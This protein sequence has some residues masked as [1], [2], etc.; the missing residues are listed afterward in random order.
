[1]QSLNLSGTKVTDGGI[2]DLQKTLP[3]T[4]IRK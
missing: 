3:N 1:L 4:S 2:V